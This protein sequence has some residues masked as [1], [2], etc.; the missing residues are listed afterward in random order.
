MFHRH[1]L[2]FEQEKLSFFSRK[3]LVLALLVGKICD[4]VGKGFFV[5]VCFFFSLNNASHI[6]EENFLN[7][8]VDERKFQ[9][10]AG[11]KIQRESFCSESGES[12]CE[13]VW[14][15]SYHESIFTNTE[16]Q[17]I[18]C[19]AVR[20]QYLLPVTGVYWTLIFNNFSFSRSFLRKGRKTTTKKTLG[21]SGC[22][23]FA[24][25]TQHGVKW[26]IK[27]SSLQHTL[28]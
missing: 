15:G 11:R 4:G 14:F 25:F 21:C 16:E 2:K 19:I 13:N 20:S 22:E 7:V 5:I 27:I 17:A 18:L 9:D 26:E 8:F 28:V 12:E 1:P 10:N 6:I 3:R 24:I 23:F